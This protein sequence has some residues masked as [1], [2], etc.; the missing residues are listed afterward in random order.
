MKTATRL[1]IVPLEKT[2]LFFCF[3]F[4]GGHWGNFC[5]ESRSVSPAEAARKVV[6]MPSSW[7]LTRS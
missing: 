4:F 5:Y 1:K 2:F 7:A 6:G 3:F